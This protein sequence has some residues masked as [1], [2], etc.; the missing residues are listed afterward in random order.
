MNILTRRMNSMESKK[1]TR[2]PAVPSG[3][4]GSSTAGSHGLHV[5][6]RR[7]LGRG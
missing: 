6:S 3:E 4:P 1:P 5:R 2:S 7:R